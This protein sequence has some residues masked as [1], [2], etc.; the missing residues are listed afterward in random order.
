[1]KIIIIGAGGNSGVIADIIQKRNETSG[2]PDE[3]L[4]FLDDDVSKKSF[5]GLP[6][7]GTVEAARNYENDPEIY[8][9]N[10]I[11]DNIIRKTIAEKYSRLKYCTLIHP[12]AIIAGDVQIGEGCAVMPGAIINTGTRLGKGVIIN[13]GAIIEHDNIIGDYVHIASGVTTA[14]GVSIGELTMLGTGTKVIQN[15]AI[16]KNVLA[17]AGSVIIRD[18]AD[19]CTVA[20][21]P[22]VV[23]K[24]K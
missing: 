18:V 15:I 1:M 22:A 21:V 20:G 2:A 19:S 17:G 12:T 16:G 7:L 3:I 5:K 8:F 13:T 14:G 11:G 23:V 6:V 24:G 4:G 10:G 9:I